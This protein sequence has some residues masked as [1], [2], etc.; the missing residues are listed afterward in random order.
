MASGAESTQK[1]RRPTAF[2]VSFPNELSGDEDDR[3]EEGEVDEDAADERDDV[4]QGKRKHDSTPGSDSRVRFVLVL[5][6][7]G[8]THPGREV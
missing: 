5:P 8:A 6:P 2:E 7:F 4:R 3:E 1:L